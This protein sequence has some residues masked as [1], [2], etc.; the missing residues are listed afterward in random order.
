MEENSLWKEVFAAKHSKRSHWCTKQS[1]SPHRIGAWKHICKYLE[2]FLQ[3]ISFKVGNGLKVKFWKDRWLGNFIL[4]EFYPTFFQIAHDL[5][6]TVAQNREG[7]QRNSIFRRKFNDWELDSLFEL[8]G[9]L[10]GFNMNQQG[11]IC[12]GPRAK[13]YTAKEG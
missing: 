9:R 13:K 7:N 2:N 8:M 6:S 1:N 11:I 5:D 3:Q 12:W 4:K 10:E